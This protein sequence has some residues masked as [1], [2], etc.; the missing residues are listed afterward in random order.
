MTIR[1]LYLKFLLWST[2]TLRRNIGCDS[3]K[4]ENHDDIHLIYKI[5]TQRHPTFI[6][7]VLRLCSHVKKT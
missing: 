2:Q 6:N 7:I 5:I 1:N 4:I 3:E